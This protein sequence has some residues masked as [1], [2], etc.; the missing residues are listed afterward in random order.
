MCTKT[1]FTGGRFIVEQQFDPKT[2]EALFSR[3]IPLCRCAD[4]IR[5]KNPS[6][7]YGT[8]HELMKHNANEDAA[9]AKA[10]GFKPPIS[11]FS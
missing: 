7:P 3:H 5:S 6:T 8:L 1:E 10:G 9:E 2:G 11:V 4:C